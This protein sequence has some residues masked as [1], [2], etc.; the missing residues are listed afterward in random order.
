RRLITKV[1]ATMVIVETPLPNMATATNWEPPAKTR[2]DMS[3]TCRGPSPAFWE[4]T[5]R[6]RPM[7]MNPRQTGQ[8]ARSPSLKE[9]APSLDMG[10]LRFGNG[11]AVVEIEEDR[12]DDDNHPDHLE[13]DDLLPEDERDEDERQDRGQEGEVG[14]VARSDELKGPVP[15]EEGNGGGKDAKVDQHQ[16]LG[17]GQLPGK[18]VKWHEEQQKQQAGEIEEKHADADVEARVL[19]EDAEEGEA[20]GAGEGEKDPGAEIDML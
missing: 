13:G 11:V 2:T 8:A 9:D 3:S 18:A 19:D 15:E 20:E 1:V 10:P 4:R 14:T 16:Q 5:P 12:A 17:S 7:G 6:E